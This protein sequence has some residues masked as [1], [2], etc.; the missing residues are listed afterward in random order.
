MFMLVK[1]CCPKATAMRARLI[2]V[3][4]NFGVVIILT[5]VMLE[6]NFGCFFLGWLILTISACLK[7]QVIS[8]LWSSAVG[9][10]RFLA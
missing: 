8:S 4:I 2:N 3:F 1:S 7:K 5:T 6:T 9:L 10:S